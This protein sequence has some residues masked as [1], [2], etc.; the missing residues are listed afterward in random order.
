[1]QFLNH[2]F[3]KVLIPI[4]IGAIN[5]SITNLTVWVFFAATILFLFMF[6][7][8]RRMT[9]I[10][11]TGQGLLEIIVEFAKNNIAESTM[12]IDAKIW[13]PFIVAIFLFISINNLMGIFPNSY[14]PTSNII[15]SA[16][17][18]IMVFFIIQITGIFKTGIKGY[19]KNFFIPG[20]PKWLWIFIT[21]VEIVSMLA[22]PFSLLL[23]LT[24]NMLAGH[25]IIIV[26]LSIITIFKNYLVAIP[27]IFLALFICFFEILISIIQAYIFS[28]L[29]ATYIK[30]IL[31]PK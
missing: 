15:F 14:V 20:V 4:K 29:T 16:T 6:F 2:F 5:L 18:A 11:K 30:D 31:N 26:I 24:A 21:P 7:Y 17:L 12:G 1:L 19:L 8:S 9:I 3:L 22:K 27:A 23:R 25:L 28:I 13:W 10:P